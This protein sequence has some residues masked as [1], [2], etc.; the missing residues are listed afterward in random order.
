MTIAAEIV[1][2]EQVFGL[3]GLPLDN[4]KIYIG[5]VNLDPQYNPVSVYWDAAGT[6]PAV[7]P[8]R[9]VAGYISYNGAPA[10]IYVNGNYSLRV[11]TKNDQQVFYLPDT[12]ITGNQSALTPV[13][14]VAQFTTYDALQAFSGDAGVVYVA[15]RANDQDGAFGNFAVDE[16][17]TTSADNGGSIVVG[18]DGRRWKRQNISIYLAAWH[19]VQE[20][21]PDNSSAINQAITSA[22]NLYPLGCDVVLPRGILNVGSPIVV[23]NDNIRLVG[24]GLYSTTLK[25]NFSASPTIKFEN[26]TSSRMTGSGVI[27]VTFARDT[28]IAPAASDVAHIKFVAVDGG[29]I[30]DIR[31]YNTIE[32]IELVGGNSLWLT[33]LNITGE[34]YTQRSR[35]GIKGTKHSNVAS[36]TAQLPTS[37]TIENAWVS[38]P[39]VNGANEGGFAYPLWIT[40][41]EN[42]TIESSYFGQGFFYNVLIEQGADNALII[43]IRFD[44]CYVDAADRNS[45][46]GDGVYITGSGIDLGATWAGVA[47]AGG[48]GSQYIGNVHFDSC[49]IKGQSGDGRDGIRTNGTPRLGAIPQAL[50]GLKITDCSILAWYRHGINLEGGT[51]PVI[52]GN[53]IRANNY[54][55]QAVGDGINIGSNCT[56]PVINANK[57]G[58]DIFG[59]SGQS[60]QKWG[61]NIGT[62]VVKYMITG[63]ACFGNVNGAVNEG[64]ADGILS[65]NWDENFSGFTNQGTLSYV[66][67]RGA[68]GIP[69]ILARSNASPAN[70]LEVIGGAATQPTRLVASGTDSNIDLSLEP[71]GTGTIKIGSNATATSD[72]PITSYI[73][74]KDASGIIRKLAIIS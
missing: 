72:A 49:T 37:L 3:D 35:Y 40:G 2:F 8:I 73:T 65:N 66:G 46:Y 74:I 44:T 20:S 15:G 56:R 16:A 43:D 50:N 19:G 21:N 31:M 28:S 52:T 42:W 71:K 53:D 30:Q 62:S 67:R 41:G 6:I 11:A 47:R 32:G 13:T 5:T 33:N 26:A 55:N 10:R 17:D 4:G 68:A 7:Q 9:T 60:Y 70:Y 54:A 51:S 48:D 25:R 69:V 27:G 58:G 63:N 14:G 38:G 36:G 22:A 1:P 34:W 64:S 29:F 39:T 45:L 12:L 23:T 24:G 57:I 61:I 59:F 18:S